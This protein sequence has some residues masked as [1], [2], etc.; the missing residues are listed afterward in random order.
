VEDSN[1]GVVY[2]EHFHGDEST[3]KMSSKRG[4]ILLSVLLT[5]L[6]HFIIYQ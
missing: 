5:A 1:Q 6:N 2:A 3:R 4:I